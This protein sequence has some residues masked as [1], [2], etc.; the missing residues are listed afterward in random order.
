MMAITRQTAGKLRNSDSNPG[1]GKGVL[2]TPEHPYRHYDP[3]SSLSRGTGR[4]F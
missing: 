1:I 4:S 2:S 3:L